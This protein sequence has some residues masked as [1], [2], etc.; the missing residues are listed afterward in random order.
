[1]GGRGGE[2]VKE[3]LSVRPRGRVVLGGV[4]GAGFSL[5]WMVVLAVGGDGG[6]AG[7]PLR[8]L[9]V[10]A[11]AGGREDMFAVVVVVVPSIR[12]RIGVGV[13]VEIERKKVLNFWVGWRTCKRRFKLS[14][15]R[16]DGCASACQCCYL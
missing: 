1:M 10:G 3:T 2:G 9:A 16:A 14:K 5:S 11:G 7:F 15:L 12:V 6:K 8:R 4:A 13:G